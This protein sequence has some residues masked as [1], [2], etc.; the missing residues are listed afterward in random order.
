MREN[1]KT[2]LILSVGLL[3]AA[4]GGAKAPA[5]AGATDSLSPFNGAWKLN[6]GKSSIPAEMAPV[7]LT[8]TIEIDGDH[9][10]ITEESMQA[11]GDL[12]TVTVDAAFDGAEHPVSG[13]PT[14][15]GAVYA[16][17]D[18]NII[19]VVT[20]KAGKVVMKEHL[21]V[22]ADGATMTD[23]M[24]KKDGSEIGTAIYEK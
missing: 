17:V 12:Q 6:I 5:Q 19:D 10:K 7:E 20:K 24:T 3:V 16:L 18:S 8:T 9:I 2:I 23:T 11:S 4:C 21:V 13:S 22:A 14:I 1:L 15:D